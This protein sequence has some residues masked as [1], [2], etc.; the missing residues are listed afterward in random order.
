IHTPAVDTVPREHILSFVLHYEDGPRDAES[1]FFDPIGKRLYVIS[2]R[3]LEVGVYSTM[4]PESGADTLTLRKVGVL[5]HT[6]VTSAAIS[7]DG[8]EV[9]A[10]SLL[11]VYYWKRKPDESIAE[12]FSRPAALQPYQPEPQ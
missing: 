5:P 8:T 1:L 6:F 11:A 12:M 9:L 10:K 7:P 4:L 3:E 2:K